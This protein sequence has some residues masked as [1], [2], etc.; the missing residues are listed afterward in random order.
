MRTTTILSIL[1]VVFAIG[2]ACA[3]S[4]QDPPAGPPDAVVDLRTREGVE[5]V[6]GKWRYSDTRIVEVDYKGP[7][8][9]LTPSGKPIKT[10]D[11]QPKAGPAD[12]DDSDWE[13]VD[14]TT[15]DAHRSTGKLCFNW[16]RIKLKIPQRIGNFDP[17]GATVAF[18]IVIDGYAEVW[19]NGRL[20]IVLGQT[21]G[22]VV[23]GFNAPNR[24]IMG[25]SIKP[26]DEVQL[27]VFGINGL[28]SRSPDNFIWIKSATLDFYK[29]MG[30][31][32]RGQCQG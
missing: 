8:A 11:Y 16:Y 25:R 18:E 7:G 6:K 1:L 32:L 10:Y 22:Q 31:H 20:P 12:Y 2:T 23:K 4:V 15:L 19:V 27:A 21:G 13:V 3:Q 5:L 28:I 9:D 29:P 17:T 24:V 30:A 26:G 14:P